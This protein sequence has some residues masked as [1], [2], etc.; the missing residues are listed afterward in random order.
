MQVIQLRAGELYADR[1]RVVRK[2]GNGGMGSVYLA[3]DL[4]LQGKLRALKLTRETTGDQTFSSEARLLCELEH[5]RLPAIYDYFPPDQNGIS[6]IVMDYIAGDTL[7]VHF[8]RHRRQIPFLFVL[9]L[10][11]EL[12]E[13]LVYL[14]AQ[15]PPIVFRDLKPSNVLLRTSGGAVLVDFGIARR[16]DQVAEM[17]TLQLGTPGFAAPE[18]MA[19]KQSDTRTDLYGLGALAYY[20][21][22]GGKSASQRTGNLHIQQDMPDVFVSL[23]GELLEAHPAN[24]PVSAAH[25]LERLRT[26]ERSSIS[27]PIGV[28]SVSDNFLVAIA[29]AYRGAGSTFTALTVSAALNRRKVLHAL[30]ELPGQ[31]GEL[32]NTLNG[33]HALRQRQS[34][35]IPGS[36]LSW[37]DEYASYYPLHPDHAPSQQLPPDYEQW[38]RSLDVPIVL[39]D[40]SSEWSNPKRLAWLADHADLLWLIADS[41]P[42]KW[43]VRRQQACIELQLAAQRNKL[44]VAWIAN[45]DQSF[46]GRHQ[47]LS[48]FPAEPAAIL[49]NIP[50]EMI[51]ESVWSN[52]AFTK[53][54]ALIRMMDNSLHK[55]LKPIYKQQGTFR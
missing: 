21:L 40:V 41:N 44:P 34:Q 53:R 14:H 37:R 7:A 16:H 35:S 1:Y 55:L 18:Q 22:A 28:S 54:P 24:R 46:E 5:A 2:L 49:P 15:Q 33:E 47:W 12:C 48:L 50:S 4:R 23:L 43:S 8:E 31:D 26:I 6:C 51:L 17:D 52:R 45:K 3:E 13:V 29:S 36:A 30:V 32:F 27:A 10:M 11:M 20:L 42:A 25:L 19:G 38:L 9:R 39:L